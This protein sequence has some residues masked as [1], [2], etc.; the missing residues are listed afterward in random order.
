VW[1]SGP[2]DVFAV[3]SGVIVHYD[4]QSWQPMASGT[5]A[6]LKGVWGSGPA[7]VFA[8]GYDGTLLHYDGVGWLGLNSTTTSIHFDG[9]GGYGTSFYVVGDQSTIFRHTQ[10]VSSP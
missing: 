3:G 10:A 2:A 6:L 7:D 8:V 1:G 4:G 9:I 5:T